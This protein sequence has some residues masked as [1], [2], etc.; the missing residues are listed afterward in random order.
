MVLVHGYWFLHNKVY[1]EGDMHAHDAIREYTHAN[2]RAGASRLVEVSGVPLTLFFRPRS[3]PAGGLHSTYFPFYESQSLPLGC[4]TFQ[5]MQK[6]KVRS[7]RMRLN[8]VMSS[9]S[10]EAKRF[11][12][13]F[14][15]VPISL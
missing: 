12:H 2:M 9:H 14:T 13:P 11:P 5:E 6:I 3:S 1:R 10:G 15:S 7:W 8:S 4:L